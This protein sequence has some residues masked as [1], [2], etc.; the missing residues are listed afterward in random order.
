MDDSLKPASASQHEVG[1]GERLEPTDGDPEV[2][3]SVAVGVALDERLAADLLVA[4]LS[5]AAGERAGADEHE[6]LVAGQ[7]AVRVDPVER[8][9]V[10]LSTRE[11]EDLVG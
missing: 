5:R 7:A 2:R 6:R 10:A 3:D 8:D 9:E 4:E 11:V 1:C